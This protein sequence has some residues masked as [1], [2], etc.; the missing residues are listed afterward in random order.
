MSVEQMWA[1]VGGL[2]LDSPVHRS[3]FKVH[4]FALGLDPLGLRGKIT[5]VKR[6]R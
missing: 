6:E 4:R 5:V 2:R 1:G 3:S